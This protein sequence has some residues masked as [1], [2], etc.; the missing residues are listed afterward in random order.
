MNILINMSLLTGIIYLPN[1]F[2]MV[3]SIN[4]KSDSYPANIMIVIKVVI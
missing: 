1:V 4:V 3:L 2:G